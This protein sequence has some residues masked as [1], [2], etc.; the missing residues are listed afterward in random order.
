MND[1]TLNLEERSNVG[2]R[3][4]KRLREAGYIPAVVYGQ[5]MESTAAQVKAG[6]LRDF[7]SKNGKNA[8]FTTEFAAEHDLS[9]LVKDIEYDPVKHNI[10][11]VDFQRVSLTEKIRAEVLVRAVGAEWIEKAGNVVVHQ[12]NDIVVECLPQDAPQH[13]DVNIS[14]MK[15]GHSLTVSQL[16][17]PEGVIPITDPQAVILSITNSNLDLQ[18]DKVDENV[19]PVGEEGNVQAKRV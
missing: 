10:V 5:G 15:P 4:V 13:I 14:D 12:L 7:L 17:L 11:H 19:V 2:W 3:K 16:T 1:S 9:L 8:M 18:V 6:E